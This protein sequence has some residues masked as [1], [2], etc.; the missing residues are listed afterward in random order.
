MLHRFHRKITLLYTL[1]TGIILTLVMAM[2]LIYSEKLLAVKNEEHLQDNILTLVS[3]L[4]SGD[5]ISYSWLSQMEADNDLI[6]HIEDNGVPLLFRGSWNPL[7]RRSVLIRRAKEYAAKNHVDTSITPVSSGISQTD[8]FQVRG[9]S[10]D[11]YQ[12]IVI[13][14][15]FAGGYKSLVL[16]SSLQPIHRTILKQRILFIVL[17]IV[18]ILA[19]LIVSWYF[20]GRILKPIRESKEQ[21]DS[22]IT[23]ASHE[24]RSPIAVIQASANAI[25]ASPSEAEHM[26]GNIMSECDRLSRLVQDLLSL[27]SADTASW[28]VKLCPTDVDTLLLNVY[29][30]YENVCLEKNISLLLSLPD[31][32]LPTILGDR[33]RLLQLLIILIDNAITYSDSGSSINIAAEASRYTMSI[34]VIDH[35]IGIPDEKK[36]LVFHRFYRGDKSRNDKSH[37]G[38]GL[39][40]ATELAKL[41]K[42][43]LS[44]KDTV[45]GGCTFTLKIPL[46]TGEI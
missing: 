36:G 19:L 34:S 35:G 31:E 46:G 43:S 44:V 33:E 38:L 17:D 16:L 15:P 14:L 8:I 24:L 12:A 3:K 37:F 39:S 42:G 20:T 1:T 29:E 22:F 2:I 25:V 28:S 21:Q 26:A 11:V 6:I 30:A 18:G 4:Q 40:I 10:R 5:V 41:H 45:G 9:D 32:S 23:A 7:T 13:T 27:A